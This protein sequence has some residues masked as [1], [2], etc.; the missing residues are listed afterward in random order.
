MAP[1]REE[2]DGFRRPEFT[3]RTARQAAYV[4]LEESRNSGNWV[5]DLLD[6]QFRTASIPARDR[7][8]ATEL[9]LGT[10]RRVATLDAVLR[11]LVAR[12]LDQ[13]EP[14]LL[15]LLR[16]GVYQ[17]LLLE[18]VPPHAS[19]HETVEL[20]KWLGRMRWS[21]FVNGV[22]RS[23][24]RLVGEGFTSEPAADAVPVAPGRYRQLNAPVFADPGRDPVGYFAEAF[25]FPGWLAQ[26]WAKRRESAELFRLGGWFNTPGPLTLRV[27]RL[28]ATPAELTQ[29]LTAAGVVIQP[30]DEEGVMIVQTQ[31]PVTGLPGY[32]D[33]A[34]AIQDL[35]AI[36]AA[37][38][39][40]PQPGQRV[41]DVCAAPGGKTCLLAELMQNSGTLVATDIRPERLDLIEENCRRLGV[42]IVQTQPV[43]EA[44]TDLPDG[45][46]DAILLDVPCSNTGVLGK[47]PEARWRISAPG[48]GELTRIQERLLNQALD[49]LCPGGRL[50]YSTCSIEPEENQDL[51]ARVLS[52]RSNITLA[53]QTDSVPGAP[54]DGGFHAVL[55]RAAK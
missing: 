39:L 20:G 16:L 35:S 14:P 27:N 8:L 33:G 30:L 15:T 40:A 51:V 28:R 4:T 12:P 23:A 19:V 37:R 26:R 25:S 44:G 48:I 13:V 11:K 10:V 38:A 21:G 9:T 18:G 45:P 29:Q 47:R 32:A 42:T 41:W 34:F 22:L 5:S 53:A 24:T 46:F 55:T 7:A 52:G 17:V 54:A 49:R 31:G 1:L 50:V 3:V 2:D 43:S 6:R 36:R